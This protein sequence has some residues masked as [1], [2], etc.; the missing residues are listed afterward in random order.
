MSLE[1]AFTAIGA[2]LT[3]LYT[4]QCEILADT[5][6]LKIDTGLLKADI[7]LIKPAI[8]EIRDKVSII[9]DVTAE[10]LSNSALI[11]S[12]V[13]ELATFCSC[14][15][16]LAVSGGGGLNTG[17]APAIS[18]LGTSTPELTA[19]K[20]QIEP[21]LA[22]Q[23]QV[24]TNALNLFYLDYNPDPTF[25][26]LAGFYG[27]NYAGKYRESQIVQGFA[28]GRYTLYSLAVSH[29]DS[30]IARYAALTSDAVLEVELQIPNL[31]NEDGNIPDGGIF[32]I[33]PPASLAKIIYKNT[34]LPSDYRIGRQSKQ[35]SDQW[36]SFVATI[37][38]YLNTLPNP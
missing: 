18:I 32:G 7:N 33:L 22:A 29:A 20:N 12:R 23:W 34:A 17:F 36:Q 5:A 24:F 35:I 1:S 16:S 30:L 37:Q 14:T 27:S 11:L 38:L 28:A 19:I 3:Q 2:K 10:I 8:G 25:I 26:G 9:E 6:L 21:V 4:K 15:S 13:K 31:F